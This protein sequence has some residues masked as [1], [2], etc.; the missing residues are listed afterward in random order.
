MRIRVGV[1]DEHVTPEVVEPVL[2]AV[3][4]LNEHMIRTGQSPTSDDLLARGAKWRPENMGDEH[5]DHGGTIAERGWGDCDDWAPLHA[6][7]HR[8]R[9]TDPGASVVMVPSGPSTFHA[10]VKRSDG[11]IESGPADISVRA[12]MKPIAQPGIHG[13]A[14]VWVCDPHDGRI[15]QGALAPTVGPLNMHCGPAVAVRGVQ[16]YYQARVD[17]PIVGSPLVAVRSYARHRPGHHRRA[18]HGPMPYAISVSH[19]GPTKH[20][21]LLGCLIGAVLAADASDMVHPLDRYRLLALQSAQAGMSPGQVHDALMH[22]MHA[23]LLAMSHATGRHP[24]EHSKELLAHM[25]AQAGIVGPPPLIIGGFFSDLG[26]IASGIVSDVGKAASAVAHTVGPWVGDILHGVEAAASVVPGLGTAISDVVAAGESA[27]DTIEAI[28]SGNPLAGAIKTAYNFAL[29]TVPAAASLHPV[30]DPVVNALIN[31]TVKKE[32]VESAIL[33]G[34]LNAVPDSPKIGPVSPRSIAA[35]LAHLIVGHLGV[36]NTGTAAA[37]KG[38]PMTAAQSAAVKAALQ[39]HPA[40]G[41]LAA[42]V[43]AVAAAAAKAPIKPPVKPAVAKKPV[44]PTKVV[45]MVVHPAAHAVAPHLV[46]LTMKKPTVVAAATAS[47]PLG[48]AHAAVH[49]VTLSPVDTTQV[50]V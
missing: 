50:H 44:A 8:A 35:S 25:H 40:G 14:N 24:E 42:A 17:V 7:T 5:F 36:K 20:H 16:G 1:P 47:K 37:P 49:R 29:G 22:Q 23:D 2:E 13:D 10:M 6:A 3:T 48:I 38:T 33:D 43:S 41:P 39:S 46:A 27:I 30:L 19:M 32:P 45:P 12:G 34:I 11:S 9:G 31:L 28:A 21:A 26:H 18:C 15:Y 4:R